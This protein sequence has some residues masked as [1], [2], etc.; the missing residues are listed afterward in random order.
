MREKL[1]DYVNLL[2]AGTD[3]TEEIRQEILQ[4][5]LDRYDDLI[6]QGKAPEAAYRLAITGI[7]D[8]N[9]ILARPAEKGAFASDAAIPAAE[10]NKKPLWK[11][12]VF[13]IGI[14]LYIVSL[15]PLFVLGSLDESLR[16]LTGG[17][18]D[19]S[20]LGLCGT[21]GICAVATVFVILGVTG[22]GTKR[23]EKKAVEENDPKRALRNSVSTLISAIGLA[24]Y[25]IISFTTGAWHITWVVFP[26]M[27]AVTGLVNA[28]LD[29]KEENDNE[30]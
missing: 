10:E 2:F 20:V 30:K 1:I 25:F 17:V 26:I 24:T 11:Q 22:K 29:L 23:A 8:I 12:I 15:I 4:N 19:F 16:Q 18:V 7:G 14:F 5:T 13:A 9:E 28:C 21:I 3:G 27:G 6:G